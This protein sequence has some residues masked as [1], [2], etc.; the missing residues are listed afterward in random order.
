MVVF[1]KLISQGWQ[2]AT[3]IIFV[4]GFG[5]DLFLLPDFNEPIT[6]FLGLTYLVVLAILFPLREWVVTRNTA[7]RIEQKL[8]SLLTFGI[9]FFLGAGL[10]FVFVYAIRSAALAVS[11]PLFVLLLLCM[12]ANEYVSTHNYRY[13]LDIGVYFIAITFY[14]IF[15]IPIVFGSVSN[16]A[17]I[18]SI[19]VAAGASFLFM[20]IM[21]RTSEIAEYESGRGFALAIGIPMFVAMLYILNL[22]PAVPLSMEASGIY[23]SI[24]RS[25]DGRYTGVEEKSRVL[26]P[27]LRVPTYHIQ[28]GNTAIY[29]FSSVSAPASVSAPISHVWEYYDEYNRKWVVATTIPFDLA[30]GRNEGYRAYSLKEHISPG[31]WRVTVKVDENRIVGRMRFRVVEGEE[32][33]T[34]SQNL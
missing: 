14:S 24:E 11:W 5:M 26:F 17:F 20:T 2:H 30:G 4:G 21:R 16:F 22:I 15:N 13:T 31:L 18:V 10:S 19:L 28:G 25:S 7:S 32:P 1:R 8:Y 3:T 33:E 34:V 23:H 6:K 29:F 12:V 9:A 27:F